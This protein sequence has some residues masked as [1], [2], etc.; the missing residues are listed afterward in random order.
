VS[1]KWPNPLK[2]LHKTVIKA[3]EVQ[4]KVN[5]SE[6]SLGNNDNHQK[7]AEVVETLLESEFGIVEERHQ[8]KSSYKSLH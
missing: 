2:G 8:Y 5:L 7:E 4:I 6:L 1:N 3:K